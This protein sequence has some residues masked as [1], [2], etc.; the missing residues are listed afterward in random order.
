MVKDKLVKGEKFDVNKRYG[1]KSGEEI[2]E[3]SLDIAR[4]TFDSYFSQGSIVGL[5]KH[6]KPKTYSY[7]PFIMNNKGK[8][9]RS[10]EHKFGKTTQKQ[11]RNMARDYATMETAPD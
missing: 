6:F 4:N 10:Y 3:A 8:M 9:V 5:S 11:T 2:W 7:E 1:N